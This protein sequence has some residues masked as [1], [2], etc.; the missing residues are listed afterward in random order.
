MQYPYEMD[1]ANTRVP[2][3]DDNIGDIIL[4]TGH[5]NI[6]GKRNKNIYNKYEKSISIN[7]I[8]YMRCFKKWTGNYKKYNRKINKKRKFDEI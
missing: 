2:V 5:L 8:P 4:N 3:I 7:T 6:N 1:I